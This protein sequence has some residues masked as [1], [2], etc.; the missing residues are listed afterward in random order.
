[1]EFE[2]ASTDNR[3]R[4]RA[5]TVIL[6]RT[7]GTHGETGRSSTDDDQFLV[8]CKHDARANNQG[9]RSLRSSRKKPVHRF[10]FP[11]GGENNDLVL[12]PNVSR[13][14]YT[15]KEDEGVR[16]LDTGT[17]KSGEKGDCMVA[18]TFGCIKN[19]GRPL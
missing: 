16:E 6:I 3:P 14:S 7:E 18:D 13:A 1:M 17:A 11:S 9:S 8:V 10:D 19:N 2:L 5:G 15:T 4:R 12:S